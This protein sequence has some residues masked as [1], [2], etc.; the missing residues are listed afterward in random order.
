MQVVLF[1]PFKTKTNSIIYENGELWWVHSILQETCI[2][3]WVPHSKINKVQ[4][5]KGKDQS[6]FAW[7]FLKEKNQKPIKMNQGI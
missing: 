1:N 5:A 3:Q 6:S 4:I 7:N 2:A